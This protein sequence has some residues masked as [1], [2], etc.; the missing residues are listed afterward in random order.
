MSCP[1]LL[2]V[3]AILPLSAALLLPSSSD[4]QQPSFDCAKASTA[5]EGAICESTML[6]TLDRQLAATY[7]SHRGG[8]SRSDRDRLLHD[9]RIWIAERDHCGADENCLAV[10]M[11]SRIAALSESATAQAPTA[12]SFMGRWQ[13]YGREAVFYSAMTLTS[14]RLAYDD[15]LTYNLQ[16]VRLGS[17]VYRVRRVQGEG[18]DSSDGP[19]HMA[20][21][22]HDGFLQLHMYDSRADPDDPPPMTP[23][24]M[25]SGGE[26]RFSVG[27]YTR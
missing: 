8:L 16:Q 13:P 5:V 10:A 20:F 12:I 24:N 6:S 17:N 19:T 27:F 26:G 21:V 9:Q 3:A 18:P 25:G 4:A 11:K 2:S 23:A 15:G 1:S 14:D 7:S 22:L